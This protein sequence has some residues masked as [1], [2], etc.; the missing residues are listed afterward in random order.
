MANTYSNLF[1]HVVFSTRGR[2]DLISQ[3]IEARVWAYI[4]GVARLHGLIAIQVGGIENHIHVL[5]L[6]KPKIAPSQIVQ[7]LKGESSRWIHGTFPEL[8]SF[9]W[10]DG[11]G[12]FS[13][14]KS[15]VR[16]VVDYIKNQREHHKEQTFEDE[17][18]SMLRLNGIDYD[19]RY[20][21]D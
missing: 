10:Q 13:V 16:E 5:I 15:A 19:E 2:K 1:Y 20:V 6:A 12:I 8:R 4:G 18:L 7:W 14:S 21:L 17:Y 9:E 11:Y 3:D